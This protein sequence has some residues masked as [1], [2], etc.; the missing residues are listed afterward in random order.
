MLKQ[1]ISKWRMYGDL[2][3]NEVWFDEYSEELLKA[4]MYLKSYCV[5]SVT[6]KELIQ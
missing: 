2:V 3:W 5:Q 4:Y 1:D 6:R